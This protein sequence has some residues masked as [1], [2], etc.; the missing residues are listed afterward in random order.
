MLDSSDVSS[1]SGCETNSSHLFTGPVAETKNPEEEE[2][3]L[4]EGFGFVDLATD[5][6]GE[7]K[8][9][10]IRHSFL[11]EDVSLIIAALA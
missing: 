11:L 10:V 1:D 4:D 7:V 6:F 2:A 8:T 9:P 5:A 3:G